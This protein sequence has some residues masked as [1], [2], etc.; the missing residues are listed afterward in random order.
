[1]WVFL[2][3]KKKKKKT[4]TVLKTER[5]DTHTA[6]MEELGHKATQFLF[7]VKTE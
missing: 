5:M 7:E 4:P 2:S 3:Y 1:M 6:E